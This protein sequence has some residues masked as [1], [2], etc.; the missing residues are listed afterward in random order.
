METLIIENESK[1]KRTELDFNNLDFGFGIGDYYYNGTC[2][3]SQVGF[4]WV[5]EL[6]QKYI[7]SIFFTIYVGSDEESDLW[8]LNKYLKNKKVVELYTML[9]DKDY[10]I[11][12]DWYNKTNRKNW[13]YYT[14]EEIKEMEV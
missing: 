11:F 5:E 6:G 1:T 3:G 14:R 7:E 9:S 13:H 2:N 8:T 12:L 10:E 4:A